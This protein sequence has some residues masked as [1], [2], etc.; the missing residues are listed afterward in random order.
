[1][2]RQ[3]SR[4]SEDFYAL[5][6]VPF[7]ATAQEI[8]KAYRAKALLLHPDKQHGDEK[9]KKRAAELFMA[10]QKA[11]EVLLDDKARAAYDSVVRA[12]KAREEQERQMDEK[13]RQMVVQLE[14]REAAVPRDPAAEEREARR[15]LEAEIQ[16]LREEGKLGVHSEQE[17]QQQTTTRAEKRRREGSGTEGENQPK[18]ARRA[19][20]TR[21][22]EDF[23]EFEAQ[24]L[25]RALGTTTTTTSSST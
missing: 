21:I 18:T 10:V 14:R 5:L 4:D 7:G 3:T 13:L 22:V 1:M 16:R 2:E 6:G 12:R 24:V 8:R 9:Q 11:K 23:D 25:A 19:P 17:Q 20:V 15:R